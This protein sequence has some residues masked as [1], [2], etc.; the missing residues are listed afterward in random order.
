MSY[1]HNIYTGNGTTTT[2]PVPFPYISRTHVFIQVDGVTKSVTTD[3]IWA[4]NATIQFNTAPANGTS[5]VMM[6]STSPGSRLVEYTTGASLTKTVLEKDSQQAY[7]LAQEALDRQGNTLG[8]DSLGT[9]WDA[10]TKR[11]Q[12]VR[13]P[14]AADDVTTKS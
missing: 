6:R 12:N 8:P 2:Y 11:I 9:N 13:A 7:Y 3:Y 1:A 10:Q 4:S 5:I 14:I